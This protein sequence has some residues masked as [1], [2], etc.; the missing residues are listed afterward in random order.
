METSAAMGVPSSDSP[1]GVPTAAPVTAASTLH[2][3]RRGWFDESGNV[4]TLSA[5]E[6]ASVSLKG[7][8][9]N[10]G[11]SKRLYIANDGG[12]EWQSLLLFDLALVADH[13]DP[14]WE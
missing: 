11:D 6:D 3:D 4:L 12:R 1:V 14:S 7:G 2:Q 8:D 9:K 10:V 13:S 5:M